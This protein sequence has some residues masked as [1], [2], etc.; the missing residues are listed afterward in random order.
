MLTE[1]STLAE[2]ETN[3]TDWKNYFVRD[4]EIIFSSA[5]PEDIIINQG[6]NINFEVGTDVSIT[7]YEESELSFNNRN[8]QP[9]QGGKALNSSN[10]SIIG[11]QY[12]YLPQF[13]DIS[14]SFQSL[15]NG[16]NGTGVSNDKLYNEL[17]KAYEALE[18]YEVDVIV[19]MGANID[20]TKIGYNPITGAKETVNAQFHIQLG[21]FL[22]K[23]S[24]NVNETF[25]VVGVESP[26]DTSQKTIANWVDRLTIRDLSD[27]LRGAN[28]VP[29][30][31]NYR[32]DV[33]AFEPYF[34][35]VGGISYFSNGAAAYA[36]MY[37]SLAPHISPTNKA[38]R[39]IFRTRFDLST[40]QLTR[41]MNE[42]YITM[43]KRPG[44]NPVI[45][46]AM[47]LAAHGSDYVRKSTARIV[48][49]T[50]DIVREV[51]DPYIGQP[52]TVE[53]RNAMGQSITRGLQ[54]MVDQG[55]LRAYN[56]NVISTDDMQ[57]LGD[58]DIELIL[59]PV[60]EIRRIRAI[61]KLR[62][63]LPA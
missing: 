45:T 19:P 52:N 8:L 44:R 3:T 57:V 39:N 11:F 15:G 37:T 35:N 22:E 31:D 48:F 61:V 32:V 47:T 46:D 36:G 26:A 30:F 50:M 60:F 43:R 9:G 38:I 25:G 21:D 51:C 53:H 58:I 55:A 34:S 6:I 28:I 7:D 27:P 20:S 5:V 54:A 33:V 10:T 23:V 17:K 42:R 29:L 14:T 13:P 62:K 12:K 16:T 4:D 49:N 63:S 59:V 40:S 18:N 56:F 2:L 1:C 41:L 24:M